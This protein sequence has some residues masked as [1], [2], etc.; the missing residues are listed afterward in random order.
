MTG[1]AGF[2][3][4]NFIQRL[5]AAGNFRGNLLNID[6]LTY[7]GNA[8]NLNNI[9]YQ[10]PDRYAFA[11][12]DICDTDALGHLIREFRPDTILHFAA[13]SHVDRSLSAPLDFAMSNVLGTTSLLWQAE[14][15]Y[16]TL[17]QAEKARFILHQ[18]STDEVYGPAGDTECFAED[19]AYRPSSP[20]AASKAA[21]DHFARAWRISYGLP[22]SI[23]ISSNNYGPWQYPEKL[24]P[25]IIINCLR[26]KSIPIY[27][28]GSFR[29]NWLY[30]SDHC[31]A[32]L[33]ILQRRESGRSY[34]ICGQAELPNIAVARQICALLDELH[35][36]DT[37]RSYSELIGYTPDRPGHD[38][39]YAV[40]MQALQRDTGW[41]P[42]TTWSAGIRATVQWYLNNW[43]WWQDL[44]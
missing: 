38:R 31:D 13:E 41:S 33:A 1:G 34:N 36:S 25:L 10:Y 27:G 18:V 43:D 6:K 15:Y 9:Q 30:V 3:G 17:S 42:A 12:L 14:L 26:H 7:A 29:R 8:T 22:L 44:P 19:A 32:I 28:D 37:L 16:Q 2:I 23:S 21:A 20:Y 39:R 24:I 4:T 35:P 11:R 5:F 40:N